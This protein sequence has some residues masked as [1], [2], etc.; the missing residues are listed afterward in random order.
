MRGYGVIHDRFPASAR[1][2][3]HAT[4][5]CI[6]LHP[7]PHSVDAYS[8]LSGHA[9]KILELFLCCNDTPSDFFGNGHFGR[10]MCSFQRAPALVDRPVEQPGNY[11]MQC[12]LLAHDVHVTAVAIDGVAMECERVYK[13]VDSALVQHPTTTPASL[14]I[15]S[16]RHAAQ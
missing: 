8:Q 1:L 7:S 2:F 4:S 12:V 16:C 5:A 13:A 15:W 11:I 9:C 6:A 14:S 3:L 10:I